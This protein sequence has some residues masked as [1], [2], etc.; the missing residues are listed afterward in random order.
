MRVK[1]K[2]VEEGGVRI[3][4]GKREDSSQVVDPAVGGGGEIIRK[5]NSQS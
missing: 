5:G 4:N 3:G 2:T 1:N